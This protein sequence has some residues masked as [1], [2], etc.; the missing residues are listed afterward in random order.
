ME[1]TYSNLHTK[2]SLKIS[3]TSTTPYNTVN[4]YFYLTEKDFEAGWPCDT[5]LRVIE[6]GVNKDVVSLALVHFIFAAAVLGGLLEY[7][8]HSAHFQ[9]V[10]GSPPVWSLL[11]LHSEFGIKTKEAENVF[12]FF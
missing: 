2:A 10:W 11:A 8:L 1:A 12:K 6:G 7:F 4:I 5:W 9:G 3:L